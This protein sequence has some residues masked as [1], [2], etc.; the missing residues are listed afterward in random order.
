MCFWCSHCRADVVIYSACVLASTMG[1]KMFGNVIWP[2]AFILS[3]LLLVE[4]EGV[5]CAD[6]QCSAVQL[7]AGKLGLHVGRV[8]NRRATCVAGHSSFEA[9]VTC[10]VYITPIFFKDLF[11]LNGFY[12]V[13]KD[14]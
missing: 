10:T 9:P 7:C 5:R 12:R 1:C 14:C 6:M 2:P 4:K 11:M 13:K 3:L 8:Q